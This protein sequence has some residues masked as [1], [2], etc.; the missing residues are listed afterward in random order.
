MIDFSAMSNSGRQSLSE[1]VLAASAG[2]DRVIDFVK[3]AALMLVVLGHCL[4]WCLLPGGAI[5]NTLNQAPHLW[6]LT[7]LLQILPL[8]F[9]IAGTGLSRLAADR[10]SGRYLARTSGLLEPAVP[11]FIVAMFISTV[12]RFTSDVPL[13]RTLGTL[14]VQLT[15]FIGVYLLL[16]ALAPLLARLRGPSSVIGLV[17]AIVGVDFARLHIAS[18]L[19][20]L[21]MVLVWAL[22]TVLGAHHER[23]RAVRLVWKLG[24]VGACVFAAAALIAFGPYAKAMITATAIPGVSNLAPPSVV[25]ACVGVAQVFLLLAGWPLLQRWLDRDSVWVPVAVFGSRAMQVYLYHL[26]FLILILAPLFAVSITAP[27][28]S[29]TWWWQHTLV[30]TCT[31]AASLVAAPVLRRRSRRLAHGLLARLWPRAVTARLQKMPQSLARLLIATTGVLLLIQ[32]ATGVGDYLAARTVVGVPV[33][34]LATWSLIMLAVSVITAACPAQ[35]AT[36]KD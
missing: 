18:G 29:A 24:A 26:L 22:F 23:L 35:S 14:M 34:P 28:L 30:F 25:L 8:F 17:L 33:Y 32:S 12:T 27:V 19:G 16:I 7:W 13:Q 1:R 21:N 6:W 36:A 10:S 2:R 20:W 15:W 3:S 5:D 11:L 31:L 9:Y 4:A